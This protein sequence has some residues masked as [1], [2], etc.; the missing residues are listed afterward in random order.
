MDLHG[1][2]PQRTET[3]LA[4]Q[5]LSRA[6]VT[7]CGAKGSVSWWG[8]W[9]LIQEKKRKKK[10]SFAFVRQGISKYLTFLSDLQPANHINNHFKFHSFIVKLSKASMAHDKV[11]KCLISLSLAKARLML[12]VDNFLSYPM[13]RICLIS[14]L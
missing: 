12:P 13:C 11:N 8:D 2:V 1:A 5:Y 10:Q 4:I 6:V 9:V 14:L 7:N 3:S